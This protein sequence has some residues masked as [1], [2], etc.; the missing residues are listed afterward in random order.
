MANEQI[1]VDDAHDRIIDQLKE[2]FPLF[3]DVGDYGILTVKE[4][5]TRER[6]TVPAA[7]LSFDSFE[8]DRER[9]NPGT[10]QKIISVRWELRV[11]LDTKD[12]SHDRAIRRLAADVALWIDGNR[13]GRGFEARFIRS[14]EDQFDPRL[15]RFNPWLI[16]FQQSYLLGESV[17]DGE[18]PV[19]TEVYGSYVPE[20]G[21][22]HEEDYERI[23]EAESL[24][25]P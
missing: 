8:P 24:V 15:I 13:F 3:V 9:S 2:K 5:E 7:I 18:G 23:E 20:I 17:W 12:P 21:A 19:P 16:E 10:G 25:K 4:G 14:E 6:L 22:A 11:M 1:T